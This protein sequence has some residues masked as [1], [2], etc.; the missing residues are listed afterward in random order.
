MDESGYA[1]I[2]K[3]IRDKEFSLDVE[4]RLKEL[5]HEQELESIREKEK[6]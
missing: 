3:Q 1:E 5:I 4:K 6:I 2:V